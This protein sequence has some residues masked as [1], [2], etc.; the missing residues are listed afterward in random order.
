[1][2]MKKNERNDDSTIWIFSYDDKGNRI[3][4]EAGELRWEDTFDKMGN[5]VQSLYLKKGRLDEKTTITR[6]N[7]GNTSEEKI[8]NSAGELQSSEIAKYNA[9]K[10]YTERSIYDAQGNL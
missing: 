9:Q 6:D 1:M 10:H 4:T 2:T 8:F 7:N 3:R 5:L